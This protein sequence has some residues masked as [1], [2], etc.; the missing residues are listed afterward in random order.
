LLCV[1]ALGAIFW[2]LNRK[3]VTESFVPKVNDSGA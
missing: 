1:S 3:G 2:F